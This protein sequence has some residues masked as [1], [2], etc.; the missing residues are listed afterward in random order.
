MNKLLIIC[1]LVLIILVFVC[2]YNIENFNSLSQINSSLSHNDC[3]ILDYRHPFIW[4]TCLDDKG[5]YIDTSI[6]I[7]K[8]INNRIRNFNGELECY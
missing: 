2:N 3:T 6:D 5:K 7:S 1:L 4:A 8:C